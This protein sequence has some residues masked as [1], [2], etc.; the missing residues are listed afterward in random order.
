MRTADTSR[1][2]AYGV[3][4]ITVSAG[5]L[6]LLGFLLSESVPAEFRIVSGL[7]L[8]LLGIYRFVV[9]RTQVLQSRRVNE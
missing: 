9:T 3:S 5:V 6:I 4:L 8:L 1:L 2:F 7:V